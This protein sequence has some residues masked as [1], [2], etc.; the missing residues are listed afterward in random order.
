MDKFIN[1][2]GQQFGRLTVIKRVENDKNRGT[3][4]LCQCN[5][6][7]K[8]KKI[9]RG[10][11]LRNGQTQ[12]CGCLH[13]EMLVNRNKTHNL[14]KSRLYKI[15]YAMKNRCYYPKDKC[16]NCYGGRGITVCDEW[17]HD[18][19]AFYDWAMAHGYNESLTI[20]R[21]DTNGNYEPSNCR[22]ITN[23][24]QQYNKSNNHLITYNGETKTA[25]QWSIELGIEYGTLLS[26]LN[27]SHWSIEKAF[28]TP[29]KRNTAKNAS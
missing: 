10:S 18:F 16:Y 20:D 25:K 1:L 29:V 9:I 23:K 21:I 5:C 14:S 3:Q 13:T 17:L 4:W 15:L 2:T 11:S 22:W 24:E 19:Q 26:R 8:T 28:T 12:S 7:N 6:Q 27:R